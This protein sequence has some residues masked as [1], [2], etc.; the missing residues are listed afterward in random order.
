MS[1]NIV[2]VSYSHKD[3][4]WK[5]QITEHLQ[6]LEKQNL[7]KIWCDRDIGAGQEWHNEIDRNLQSAKLAVLLIS[8]SFLTSDFVLKDEVPQLLDQH[9]RKG[10]RLIP[11]LIN[12]CVWQEV[13]WLKGLQIRPEKPIAE[14]S[15]D[16]REREL[17]N[18]VR[19]IL[20]YLKS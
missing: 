20:E 9:R 15:K 3:K 11:I 6:V 7:L 14:F 10:M 13:T 18:I 4:G 19:E 16:R 8:K 17:A 12:D 5:H 1:R 2:F